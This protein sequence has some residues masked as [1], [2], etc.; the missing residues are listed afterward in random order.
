MTDPWQI[1]WTLLPGP[2]G[3]VVHRPAP[4]A[5]GMAFCQAPLDPYA[6]IHDFYDDPPAPELDVCARCHTAVVQAKAEVWEADRVKMRRQERR[7]RRAQTPPPP[8][9]V[10]GGLPG[11]GNRR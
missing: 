10:R 1:G 5:S 3:P 11:L 7:Q 9:V 8:Q 4:D 6:P 2:E